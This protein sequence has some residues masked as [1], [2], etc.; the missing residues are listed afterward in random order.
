MLDC[1]SRY[2]WIAGPALCLQNGRHLLATSRGNHGWSILNQAP[3]FRNVSTLA[4]TEGFGDIGSMAQNSDSAPG[5][6]ATT[7]WSVVL[8]A[9]HLDS[10]AAPEALERL[11]CAYW[12]PL[13]AFVRRSGYDPETAKD[14]TQS[15]FERLIEKNFLQDV[16]RGKGRFRSFMLAALRHFLANEW[17]R[18][19]TV[20]RGGGYR[21]VPLDEGWIESR[22]LE[23]AAVVLTPETLYERRWALTVLEA[24]KAKL[25]ADYAAS[26]RAKLFD[27]LQVY[28]SGET[29]LA[30]YSE[31]ASRLE[32]SIDAVKKAV[33]RLRRRYGEFLRDEVAQT[34]A[35]PS[36]VEEEI[37]HLR[38]VLAE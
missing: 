27:A 38:R 34:L 14:L 32:L 16:S 25:A 5:I 9:G 19:K 13:Y 4:Q 33:E 18:Q 12:Y 23:D 26:G 3:S 21:F 31:V 7:H 2:P 35:Q 6:F 30:P 1:L 22:E 36:E 20:R 37:R 8:N 10:P 28:L 15:F 29:G 11:C 24:A 17:D